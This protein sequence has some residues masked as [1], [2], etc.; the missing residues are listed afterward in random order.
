M[1]FLG[2]AALALQAISTGYGIYKGETQ[3]EHSGITPPLSAG[4]LGEAAGIDL[5]D[6]GQ[7]RPQLPGYGQSG[8]AGAMQSPMFTPMRLTDVLRE[9]Q[10]LLGGF[11]QR[12]RF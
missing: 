7:V 4:Q 1:S 12:R 6:V 9:E 11:P 2:I 10:P 5:S 8:L 3:E